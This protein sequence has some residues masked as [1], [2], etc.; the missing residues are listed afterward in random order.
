MSSALKGQ[1]GKLL[2][3]QQGSLLKLPGRQH[4]KSSVSSIL[5]SPRAQT[6][7]LHPMV[8]THPVLE[9]V[10]HFGWYTPIAFQKAE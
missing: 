5:T 7:G 8:V 3:E 6:L 10:I 2:L 1:F 9:P 4:E